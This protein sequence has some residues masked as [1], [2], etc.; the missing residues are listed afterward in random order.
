MRVST[1]RPASGVRGPT[2]YAVLASRSIDVSEDGIA[3]HTEVPLAPGDR[4]LVEA[5]AAA[6]TPCERLGWVVWRGPRQ[7]MS[8]GNVI[9]IELDP[10]EDRELQQQWAMV[11]ASGT[12][13]DN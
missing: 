8:D 13:A 10:T 6:D 11:Q 5:W 2:Y 3:L 12:Q 7:G 1:V 9:G 4:V